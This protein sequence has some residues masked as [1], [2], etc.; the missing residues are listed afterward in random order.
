MRVF[1]HAQQRGLRL[2]PDLAQLIRQELALVDRQ[3]LTDHR[4]SETFLS[5]LDARGNVSS[6]L[7]A[8][9]TVPR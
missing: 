9:R 1:L 4:V 5:I 3:F 2:H 8:M 6:A 7:R